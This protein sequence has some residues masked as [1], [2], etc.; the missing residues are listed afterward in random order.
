[1]L[2]QQKDFVL[3][4]HSLIDQITIEKSEKIRWRKLACVRKRKIS[5]LEEENLN[6]K[7]ALSR[8][9]LQ[10]H[11][12]N[13]VLEIVDAKKSKLEDC[14]Y[15]EICHSPHIENEILDNEK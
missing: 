1:M 5:S 9:G 6:L 13:N 15:P 11:F 12:I 4:Q 3:T 7:L 10:V 14:V 2:D 8:N